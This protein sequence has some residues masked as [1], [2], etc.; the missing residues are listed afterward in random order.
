[1]LEIYR[2]QGDA[3]GQAGALYSMGV[4]AYEMGDYANARAWLSE[5]ADLQH[6]VPDPK[7][8]AWSVMYLGMLDLKQG[9]YP[10]AAAHH[11]N[12]LDNARARQDS[13]QEGIHLTNLARVHMR[14]GQYAAA[15]QEF[16]QSLA[17]KQRNN[18]L[19]GQAFALFYMGLTCL[20]QGR[21]EEAETYLLDSQ[22]MWQQVTLNERGLA[23]VEQG[24]GLL[25]LQFGQ[26]AQAAEYL[27]S[28]LAR[29]EK[30]VLKAEQIENL[31]HL[32]RAL[33][34]LGDL[35][36]AREVS[37]QAV[38]RLA[39]QQDV[40]E[41]QAISFNHYRVLQSSGDPAAGE[42]LAQAA[43]VM[44][45]QARR[46]GDAQEREIFLTQVP[47]NREI[48]EALKEMT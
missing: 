17:L 23:Y 18:D 47:V 13:F 11:Q 8:E 34:G 10:Q 6:G 19:T 9:D 29:C 20:Y 1:M 14:L 44:Q 33:L 27:R 41:E 15:M 37:G 4:K 38:H 7:S 22:S 46:I 2:A 5:A 21:K 32:G 42:Y 16:E 26:Y 35:E 28:A 25:A 48:W 39:A 31:S 40:E 30:L 24:L 3:S 45:E 36:E 43:A 12:A